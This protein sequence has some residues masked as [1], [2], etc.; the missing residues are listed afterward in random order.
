MANLCAGP[1]LCEWAETPEEIELERLF[2]EKG[3]LGMSEP[4]RK[5]YYALKFQRAA[6]RRLVTM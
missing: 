6:E 3:K 4:D 5:E 2:Q 1:G